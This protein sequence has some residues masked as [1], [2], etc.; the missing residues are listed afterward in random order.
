MVVLTKLSDP[1]RLFWKDANVGLLNPEGV[2]SPD[3]LA[4]NEYLPY[5]TEEGLTTSS[6]SQAAWRLYI[7]INN[8]RTENPI[9]IRADQR[10]QEYLGP[11]LD[12]LESS[13]PTAEQ[14]SRYRQQIERGRRVETPERFN[15]NKFRVYWLGGI[16]SL[17]AIPRNAAPAP[18]QIAVGNDRT[19]SQEELDF[20]S[21]DDVKDSVIEEGALLKEN[22]E[23]NR[24]ARETDVGEDQEL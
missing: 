11:A 1:L 14:V 18:G 19:L 16:T 10:M 20:M 6:G 21:R 17:Y 5:L 8:L 22:I 7:E 13:T 2:Y 24:L 4:L 23:R 15:R 12:W 3:N 9:Y